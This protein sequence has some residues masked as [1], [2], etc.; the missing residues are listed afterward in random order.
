MAK[1]ASDKYVEQVWYPYY[2]CIYLHVP[3]HKPKSIYVN[4]HK[5][6]N[7]LY[8]IAKN[9]WPRERRGLNLYSR[10]V[11]WILKIATLEGVCWVGFVCLIF[12]GALKTC[13]GIF[14]PFFQSGPCRDTLGDNNSPQ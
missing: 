6:K 5:F 7:I 13:S 1:I 10:S 9:P 2:L 12:R 14:G 11:F 3:E 4:Y 8:H